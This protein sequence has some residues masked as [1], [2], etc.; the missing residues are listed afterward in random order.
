M[1]GKSF[2][3]E[4][5]DRWIISCVLKPVYD[6]GVTFT[7]LKT[8]FLIEFVDCFEYFCFGYSKVG[9]VHINYSRKTGM[10]FSVQS[11]IQ[12]KNADK[13]TKRTLH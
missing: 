11:G 3:I 12:R 1:Y 8:C 5:V 9:Y 6:F 10:R 2:D 13:S 7:F 4:G